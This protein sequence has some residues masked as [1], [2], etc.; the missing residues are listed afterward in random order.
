MPG[1]IERRVLRRALRSTAN[2]IKRRVKPVTPRRLGL[3]Q[4]SVIVRVRVRGGGAYAVVRYRGKPSFYMRIYEKG[5]SRQRAR[6]FF[7]R[8]IAG[9]EREVTQDFT[10]ALRESVE[11]EIG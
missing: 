9:Y 4:R 2:K 5:S 6:P 1:K 8:A 11:R 3:A 10:T 7:R